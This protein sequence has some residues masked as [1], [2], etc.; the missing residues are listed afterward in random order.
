MKRGQLWWAGLREPS[1]SEPGFRRPVLIIQA[2]EFNQSNI[3]TVIVAALT[4]NQLLARAPGNVSLP[5]GRTGL[6]KNSVINVSQVLT[7]D[8]KFLFDKIGTIPDPTLR[9]VENG[10]RL[11]LGLE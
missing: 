10:I 6:T 1:A 2:D 3:S 9:Q 7:L 5:K 11:A 4:S 8:K